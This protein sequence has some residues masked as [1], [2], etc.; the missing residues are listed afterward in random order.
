MPPIGPLDL[1]VRLCFRELGFLESLLSAEASIDQFR[2]GG[3]QGFA[4]C[5]T[6]VSQSRQCLLSQNNLQKAF[7]VLFQSCAPPALGFT[8][9]D[10][11]FLALLG[12]ELRHGRLHKDNRPKIQVER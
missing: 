10:S 4:N 11:A 7:G 2:S 5:F 9:L 3:M 8:K 12:G 1:G 6:V